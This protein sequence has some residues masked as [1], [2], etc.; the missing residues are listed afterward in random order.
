MRLLA[1]VAVAFIA[2][3]S[4]A[5]SPALTPAQIARMGMANLETGLGS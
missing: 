5:Q 2:T 4:S 1:L 3:K